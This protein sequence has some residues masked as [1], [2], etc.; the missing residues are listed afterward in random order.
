MARTKARID[1]CSKYDCTFCEVEKR[2]IFEFQHLH[3]MNTGRSISIEGAVKKIVRIWG[4]KD[5]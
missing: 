2:I 3:K 5:Q 1:E 4:G